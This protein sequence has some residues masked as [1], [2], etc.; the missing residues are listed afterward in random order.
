MPPEPFSTRT[1]LPKKR[2]SEIDSLRAIA[3][4]LVIIFH[5]GL[6]PAWLHDLLVNTLG[7]GAIGVVMFFAISGFLIPYSLSGSRWLAIL[8]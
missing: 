7:F 3:C 6:W 4:A 5:A 8:D 1:T 2:F